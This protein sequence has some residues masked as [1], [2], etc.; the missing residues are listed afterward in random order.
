MD[1]PVKAIV[2]ALFPYARVIKQ[3]VDFQCVR[4]CK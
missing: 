1:G 4:R 2:K 3:V